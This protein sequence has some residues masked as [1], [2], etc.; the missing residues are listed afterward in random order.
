MSEEVLCCSLEVGHLFMTIQ[1]LPCAARGSGA[2]PCPTEAIGKEWTSPR[3]LTTPSPA[4]GWEEVS[5]AA[6][7]F[8]VCEH[9]PMGSRG[10]TPPPPSQEG[11]G[12]GPW[13]GAGSRWWQGNATSHGCF[14]VSSGEE[15]GA[16]Q[17]G[18]DLVTGKLSL[19]VL[20]VGCWCLG[21]WLSECCSETVG[22]RQ[23]G[24]ACSCPEPQHPPLLP[25]DSPTT[26]P[27]GIGL[28]NTAKEQISATKT[29]PE[30]EL[31]LNRRFSAPVAPRGVCCPSASIV[32]SSGHRRNPA[33]NSTF[34][35][36]SDFIL[37][38][39]AMYRHLQATVQAVSVIY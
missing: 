18:W 7:W 22:K 30:A 12:E 4:H 1:K 11:W 31:Q 8:R 36:S 29:A 24:H 10:R 3:G 17:L 16:Y 32:T 28:G 6:S 13:V 23:D 38:N 9:V 37:Q 27:E 19:E 35:S 14:W 34:N 26:D 15:T 21:P 25:R 2:L 5:L 20:G 33:E 39:A